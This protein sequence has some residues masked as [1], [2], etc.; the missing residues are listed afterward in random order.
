[1]RPRE[2]EYCRSSHSSV[3][4]C[5]QGAMARISRDLNDIPLSSRIYR[6]RCHEYGFDL[7]DRPASHPKFISHCMCTWSARHVCV[8][9]TSFPEQSHSLQLECTDRFCHRSDDE[10]D[11]NWVDIRCALWHG[12]ALN[13]VA[14][15]VHVHWSSIP[16]KTTATARR[17]YGS[18][19]GEEG[20]CN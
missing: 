13:P 4:W 7:N 15:L 10:G 11:G 2:S 12:F 3:C 17:R 20:E 19:E 14:L 5:V 18:G 8:L 1:M 16:C 9:L 6:H